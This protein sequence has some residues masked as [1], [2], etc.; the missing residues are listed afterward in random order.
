MVKNLPSKAGDPR[1]GG[2]IP[3]WGRSPGAGNGNELQYS[4]LHNSMD[5]GYR[6]QLSAHAHT[7]KASAL[8]CP[9]CLQMQHPEISTAD[10]VSP[11][12]QAG[13]SLKLTRHCALEAGKG[14]WCPLP[15]P[16]QST[17]GSSRFSSRPL[18]AYDLSHW[19][20]RALYSALG[21][22]SGCAFIPMKDLFHFDP[23]FQPAET[24]EN[25]NSSVQNINSA[26]TVF[27]T[28]NFCYL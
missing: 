21:Q 10:Q 28:L 2:W 12:P 9:A 13:Q 14:P 11:V 26:L 3:G 6:T 17:L 4:C 18:T 24:S 20:G 19:S 15:A 16:P 22:G 27:H 7:Y 25:C 5:R 8:V 23:K 1:D